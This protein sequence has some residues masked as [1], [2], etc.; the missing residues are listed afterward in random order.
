MLTIVFRYFPLDTALA[1]QLYDLHVRAVEPENA[2]QI[3]SHYENA[4]QQLCKDQLEVRESLAA[5]WK[6]SSIE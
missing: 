1:R 2:Q 5:F 6:I 4:H 3:L